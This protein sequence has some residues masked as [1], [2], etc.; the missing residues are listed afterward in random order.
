[1]WRK[2]IRKAWNDEL[3]GARIYGTNMHLFFC[4]PLTS[5][6]VHAISS[7]VG[8]KCLRARKGPW[9]YFMWEMIWPHSNQHFSKTA[10]QSSYLAD[11]PSVL[12]VLIPSMRH[13]YVLAMSY[14]QACPT[15]SGPK[16]M[17]EKG[18]VPACEANRAAVIRNLNY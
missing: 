4:A 7:H 1:V 10:A 13:D 5:T 12:R 8:S 9:Y 14:K 3:I 16:S 2:T 6:V 18:K 15:S 11:Q 17:K